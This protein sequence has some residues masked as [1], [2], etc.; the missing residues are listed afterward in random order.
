LTGQF[1]TEVSLRAR[2]VL[3][4]ELQEAGDGDALEAHAVVGQAAADARLDDPEAASLLRELREAGDDPWA[5][6]RLLRALREAGHS[7]A[8][9]A[10]AS[11]AGADARLDDPDATA[12]LL[13]ELREVGA[14]DAVT[15]LLA[16]DPAAHVPGHCR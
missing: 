14:E 6:A 8:L 12:S 7:D 2:H 15:T 16:R 1:G 10:L 13:R 3:L 5:A 9:A 4:R 11:R